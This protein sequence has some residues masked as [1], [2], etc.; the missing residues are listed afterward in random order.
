MAVGPGFDSFFLWFA[1]LAPDG[2]DAERILSQLPGYRYHV[3]VGR[4]RQELEEHPPALVVIS[5]DWRIVP[6]ADGQRKA[7]HNFLRQRHY[8]TV[9]FG[10]AWFALRPDRFEQAKR[11]GLLEATP[12][13]HRVEK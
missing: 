9:R 10:T 11:D 3:T 12:D 1:T 4:F 5:G 7:L 13:R 8:M 2:W 6:Y